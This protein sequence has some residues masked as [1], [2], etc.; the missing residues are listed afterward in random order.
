MLQFFSQENKDPET[1]GMYFVSE[2]NQY[3]VYG[4]LMTLNA[5]FRDTVYYREIDTDFLYKFYEFIYQYAVCYVPAKERCVESVFELIR[6]SIPLGE[7]DCVLIQ[8][9]NEEYSQNKNSKRLAKLLPLVEEIKH[10][11]TYKNIVDAMKV[12]Y[13]CF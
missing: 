13:F 5:D 4:K 11:F 2:V 12:F 10:R 8:Y 9:L 1:R 7:S 3:E 6:M